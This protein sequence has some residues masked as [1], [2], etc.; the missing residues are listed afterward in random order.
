MIDLVNFG[1][2]LRHC[3]KEKGFSQEEVAERIGVSAQAISKWEKGEGLPDLYHFQILTQFYR[4]SADSLL[5]IELDG[6]VHVLETIKVGRVV[7]EVVHKTCYNSC[8][9]DFLRK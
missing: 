7:F 8:R 2:R 3:R 9:K 1:Q 4:I 6:E 5:E